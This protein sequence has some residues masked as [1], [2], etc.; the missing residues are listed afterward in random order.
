MEN[1]K[2]PSNKSL[3]IVCSIYTY[4]GSSFY[5]QIESAEIELQE[6]LFL[7]KKYSYNSLSHVAAAGTIIVEIISLDESVYKTSSL[8]LLIL[9]AS[10][11]LWRECLQGS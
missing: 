9:L 5:G 8:V 3:F 6:S 11:P 1:C 2:Q 7:P 4:I 10:F